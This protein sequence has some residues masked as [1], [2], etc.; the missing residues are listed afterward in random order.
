MGRSQRVKGHSFER[1]IAQLMRRWFP[2]AKRG[3]QTRGG[4]KEQADVINTPY[5]I[6][7]KV[8]K[9]PNIKAAYLQAREDTQG[10]PPIAITKWDRE[11]PLVTMSLTDW[12]SMLDDIWEANEDQSEE[13]GRGGDG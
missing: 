2:D 1:K 12:F 3:Y 6:E 4:G 11:E 8:G 13:E 5:H 7:C 9:K 10:E